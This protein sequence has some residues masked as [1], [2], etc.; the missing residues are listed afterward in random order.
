MGEHNANFDCVCRSDDQRRTEEKQEREEGSLRRYGDKRVGQS[1]VQGG[2]L[3][4]LD[5]T[6]DGICCMS[7]IKQ[8]K[9][10][11]ATSS[12]RNVDVRKPCRV[13]FCCSFDICQ[14]DFCYDTFPQHPAYPLL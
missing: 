9:L 4:E 12:K 14:V 7:E 1:G 5:D 11:L 2:E 13:N 6:F 10:H 3:Y 8:E